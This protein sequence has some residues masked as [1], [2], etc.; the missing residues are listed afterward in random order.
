[1]INMPSSMVL[2]GR[3]G[4]EKRGH[5]SRRLLLSRYDGSPA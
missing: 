2:S 3:R 1:L 5:E 4:Q